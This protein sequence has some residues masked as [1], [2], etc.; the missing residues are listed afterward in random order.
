[1]IDNFNQAVEQAHFETLTAL[2][3]GKSPEQVN[4]DLISKGWSPQMAEQ[5]VRRA[6]Q[7]KKAEFR[8]AGLRVFCT[9]IALLVL[10]VFITAASYSAAKGGGTYFITIGL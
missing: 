10:G 4:A 9:G 7:V 8:K 2:A 3:N 6:H 1:M 5:I